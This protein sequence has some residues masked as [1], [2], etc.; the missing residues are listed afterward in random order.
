[1]EEVRRQLAS[2]KGR[3][4]ELQE[5]KSSQGRK[6]ETLETDLHSLQQKHAQLQDQHALILREGQ[7][8]KQELASAKKQLR[9]NRLDLDALMKQV[10]KDQQQ[11]QEMET[12]TEHRVEKLQ[13]ELKSNKERLQNQYQ[14]QR[15]KL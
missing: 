13:G 4:Q 7:Q 5:E 12:R 9:E 6:T 11:R 2:E 15:K 10:K 8:A 3:N 1:M 14:E